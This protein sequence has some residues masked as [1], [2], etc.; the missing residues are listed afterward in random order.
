[1]SQNMVPRVG[2]AVVIKLGDK[3]LLGTRGKEPN[4]GK[5]VL[6]GGG[7]KFLESL[8]SALKREIMEETGLEI[9]IENVIGVYEIIKPPDEHRVIVYWWAVHR[10]GNIKP[11]SD[12]LDAR[13]FSKEEIRSIVQRGESTEIVSKVLKDIGWV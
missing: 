11:S 9:E 2:C 6:P 12:I 13:F 5:W 1:M 3:I 7:V 4:R 10:N 8:H